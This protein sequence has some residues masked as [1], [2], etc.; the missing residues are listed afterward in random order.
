[1]DKFLEIFLALR[2][3]KSS[4][5]KKR[6]L[7]KGYFF[8]YCPLQGTQKFAIVKYITRYNEN[9]YDSSVIV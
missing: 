2:A 6:R 7:W 9:G 1:M 3:L 8:L 5:N 4:R